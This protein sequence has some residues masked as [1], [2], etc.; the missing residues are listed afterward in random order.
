[1]RFSAREPTPP[2]EAF[3]GDK[4]RYETIEKQSSQKERERDR[5]K[6]PI[7]CRFCG[8]RITDTR[9]KIEVN[10]AHHHTFSNPDGI[11]FRIGC[12]ALANGCMNRGTPTFEFTWFSGF[13]WRFSLCANCHAHLGWFY[14]GGNQSFFGLI[15]AHI[16]ER[17]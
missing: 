9:Y 8:H 6:K 14:Q 7:L 3:K 16:V 2:L 1:M 12:F 5:P 11:V 17:S 4:S 15:L 13:A 10:G